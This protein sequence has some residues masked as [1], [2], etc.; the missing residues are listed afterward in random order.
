MATADDD[1][2]GGGGNDTLDDGDGDDHLSADEGDDVLQ[3][4][5]RGPTTSTP[6]RARDTI[7]LL[8]DGVKDVVFCGPGDGGD[9]GDRLILVG[10]RDSTR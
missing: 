8:S 6:S 4:R 1:L 10:G 3:R 7:Y 2:D 5:A 9:P